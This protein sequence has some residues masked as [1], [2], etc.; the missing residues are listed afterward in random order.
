MESLGDRILLD[1]CVQDARAREVD[2]EDGRQLQARCILDGRGWRGPLPVPCGYQKFVGRDVTL[3]GPHGLNGPILMDAT[4]RQPD[5]Y[6][7]VYVLPW[8]ERS[9][10]IEETDY[11]DTPAVDVPGARSRIET[12]ATSRGWEIE[13]VQREEIGALPIP[14]SGAFEHVWPSETAAVPRVGVRAGLFHPTT[15]YSLPD[16]ARLALRLV[17]F[18][19]LESEAVYARLRDDARKAWNERGYFRFLNKMMFRAADPKERVRIFERFYGLSEGLIG[20]F[21]A[22]RIRWI[23]RVRLLAGKPPVPLH[24]ALRCVWSSEPPPA[25]QTGRPS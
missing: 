16:A 14:L 18:E 25:A 7:F 4:V 19:P 5:A 13:S 21:Y 20:R 23:D 8:S 2:L 1:T 12:Y 11:S 22:A 9:L 6:R 24:R 10:L 3:R 15:G 17:R